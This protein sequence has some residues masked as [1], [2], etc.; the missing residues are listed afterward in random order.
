MKDRR[1]KSVRE[2]LDAMPVDIFNTYSR[3]IGSLQLPSERI[4]ASRILTFLCYSARPVTVAEAAEFAILEDGMER[5]DPQDRFE[6]FTDI[7]QVL[8]SLVEVCNGV[9]ALSHRS[10]QEF[11]LTGQGRGLLDWFDGSTELFDPSGGADLY[12][13]RR[14]L[15]YLAIN[16]KP[17]RD[18]YQPGGNKKPN[19][20]HLT[21]LL[22]SYPLLEYAATRWP[23]HVRRK[24]AQLQ[25]SQ[26][27]SSTLKLKEK[28][29]LWKA[30]LMLQPADIWENQLALSRLVC[31]VSI[32]GAGIYEWACDFWK[33][34]QAYRVTN[35]S[36]T[37]NHSRKTSM[38]E[39]PACEIDKSPASSPEIA[40]KAK[41]SQVSMEAGERFLARANRDCDSHQSDI[42]RAKSVG[43]DLEIIG[44]LSF[45]KGEVMVV[46]AAHNKY[47][48]TGSIRGRKGFV[49]HS[50]IKRS[51]T[52]LP[53]IMGVPFYNLAI[54]LLEIALQK[55]LT[56]LKSTDL[57]CISSAPE[58]R[59]R[60]A[61]LDEYIGAA[62][63]AMGPSYG[64]II[65]ECLTNVNFLSDDAALD[66]FAD[67]HKLMTEI[68]FP[69]RLF[70]ECSWTMFKDQDNAVEKI[71]LP[72]QAMVK[73]GFRASRQVVLPYYMRQLLRDSR[74]VVASR[75]GL[76]EVLGRIEEKEEDQGLKDQRKVSDSASKSSIRSPGGFL[77]DEDKIVKARQALS[78]HRFEFERAQKHLFKPQHAR[79]TYK[80]K[81]VHRDIPDFSFE[82]K[83]NCR[84]Y[85][86]VAGRLRGEPEIARVSDTRWSA[87][88]Q[89]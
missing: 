29:N 11:L 32:R 71:Y 54:L 64:T 1:V 40:S 46:S 47:W 42:F 68:Q 79:P 53:K 59:T 28:S 18:S 5:I 2:V 19:A 30:W 52:P 37:P 50:Y 73:S 20:K 76:A 66:L 16:Q 35:D 69:M 34:R 85:S 86:S 58:L 14:C 82:W 3:I 21:K 70:E 67:M 4:L 77:K 13:A 48:W 87:G 62:N 49:H 31:E 51:T 36:V 26:Q 43:V 27:M 55:S 88:A 74:E 44:G 56:S 41:S 65:R 75:S 57:K 6:N 83:G 60:L 22:G 45:S 23:H 39:S 78:T 63:T 33:I 25:L 8:G 81:V 38:S 72:L 61:P 17:I 12:I 24:E 10:V 84:V 15:Q 7:V 89:N 9:L 80:D